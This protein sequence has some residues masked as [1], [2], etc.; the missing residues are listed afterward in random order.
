MPLLLKVIILL[1]I[2]HIVIA[3]DSMEIGVVAQYLLLQE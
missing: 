3:N 2:K 1:S